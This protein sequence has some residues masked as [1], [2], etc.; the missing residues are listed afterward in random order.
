[1]IAKLLIPNLD[2]NQFDRAVQRRLKLSP[3]EVENIQ[4]MA[5]TIPAPSSD[6]DKIPQDK[7]DSL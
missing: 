7:L 5:Q 6:K 1:L 2:I 4:V 3:E